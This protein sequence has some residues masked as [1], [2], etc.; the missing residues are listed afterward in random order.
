MAF[1]RRMIPMTSRTCNVNV[2]L[3]RM[4]QPWWFW[5]SELLVYS[6]VANSGPVTKGSKAADTNSS[7]GNINRCE[8]YADG[9]CEDDAVDISD[10]P[11]CEQLLGDENSHL[12][13]SEHCSG[14]ND[15]KDI[16]LFPRT[17]NVVVGRTSTSQSRY[18][19][20][21]IHVAHA[22][23]RDSRIRQFARDVSAFYQDELKQIQADD[24]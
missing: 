21:F 16:R 3:C 4:V 24:D 19:G 5:A 12:R 1:R 9:V 18:R 17:C 23:R 11:V 7:S 20:G 22:G 2:V 13:S 6:S 14:L 10:C 15:D 8:K